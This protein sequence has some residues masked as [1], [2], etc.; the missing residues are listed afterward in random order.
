[1]L[2]LNKISAAKDALHYYTNQDNYYLSDRDSLN[3][4]SRWIGRGAQKLQLSGE[5]EPSQFLQLLDGQLPSGQL[6][7][8]IDKGVRQHRPG[9]D[10]T[11]S[12]PKS[13]SI[14]A[15][16][17]Q[18]ERLLQAHQE[19][20][21]ITF[22]R[23]EQL[24]A[25]ARITFN[26]ET[27]FEKTRNLVAA[28][29][30]HTTS[31]ELDPDL[32]THVPIL[33]MTERS[34]GLW[35]SLSSRAK[36]DKEHLDHGFRELI[37]SNQH[38]LGLVYMSSLAKK[39]KELGYDIRI[40]DR[41]GNF[42]IVGISDEAITA[43]SKRRVQILDDM[44]ERGTSS[45]K[46]AEKS[47]LSTRNPKT[48]IDS[49]ALHQQW[50][51]EIKDL[52][53]DLGTIIQDSKLNSGRG[54]VKSTHTTPL[55]TD[56]QKAVGDALAHLSE[57]STQIQHGALVRQAMI[58]SAGL[59]GHEDIEREIESLLAARALQ[60]K[61]LE[62]YTTAHL[63]AREKDFIA[64]TTNE[65]KVSF[66]IS[67]PNHGLTS[68]VFKNNERIQIIDIEGFRCEKELIQ[69]MV[70]LAEAH[71]LNSY[72]L[73]PGSL[74]TQQ[75]RA[76]IKHLDTGFI[77]RIKNLFKD[78][79]VHTVSGFQ[80]HYGKHIKSSPFLR[81]KQDLVIV[82]DAQ[83]LSFD[84]LSA[85]S[86]ITQ[87]HRSKLILLNNSAGTLGFSAGNPIKLLKEQGIH[88]YK[89][90]T[91]PIKGALKLSIGKQANE[92]MSS[93]WLQLTPEQQQKSA[94][95]ALNNKQKET[96][97]SQIREG[98]VQKG[99]LSRQMKK[100]AVL[101]TVSLT[102]TEKGYAH[103]YKVGDKITFYNEGRIPKH[104]KVCEVGVNGLHLEN[105][106]GKTSL[107]AYDAKEDFHVSREK[108]LEV[109]VGERLIN[110]QSLYHQRVKYAPKS[111]FVVSKIT[112][113]GIY[114]RHES[115][116]LFLTNK[117][118]SEYHFDY[119]YC[120][121]PHEIKPDTTQVFMAA[122]PYQLN[123]NLIGEIGENAQQVL[124]FTDD[125]QKAQR[126]LES[127]QLKWTAYDVQ[128]KKPDL[129]YRDMAYANKALEREI[130][131]LIH[132][133]SLKSEDK[134]GIAATALTYALAKCTER[135]AAFKHSDLMTHALMHALGEADFEDIAPLLKGRMADSLVYLDTYWTTK[136]ALHLE[137]AI[138]KVNY[139]EQNTVQPIEPSAQKL[140]SLPETLTQ[141]QKD[142]ITLVV[143][144]SDRFV[145]IQGLAGVGKTTMMR[146]VKDIAES[147][148]FQVLGL[149]PTHK[150]VEE[151]NANGI[152]AQT[153]DSFLRN[154]GGLGAN[155][156]VI[157]DESSMIDNEKYH[158][159]QQKCIDSQ[160]RMVFTG[161]IT[162]LQSLASGI[163]HELT[164]KSQ[165]QKTAFMTEIVRQN[166]NPE[167]KKAA[168][169]ASRREIGKAFELIKNINPEEYVQ[170][171]TPVQGLNHSSLIEINCTDEEG[172][173]DY[174]SIYRA[175]VDDFLSRTHECQKNTLIVAH[176][177]EDRTPIEVLIREG[178]HKQHQLHGQDILCKRL[179]PVSMDQ[180]DQVQAHSF[181]PGDVIRFG[182][183]YSV[184]K[185]DD[186]FTVKSIDREA[187][188]LFCVDES[189]VAFTISA[190]I[191][192][193]TMPS[194]YKLHE[195]PLASGDRIRLKRND[196]ARG[197]I[198]NEEYTV[199]QVFGETVGLSNSKNQVT[200]NLK[201]QLD[202]HW[203]YSYTNTA[204]SS[205]GATSK[206]MIALELED[207]LVVTTHRSHEIDATRASH[208]STF[209]TDNFEGLVKRL[210]DPLKQRDADKTSA[211][212]T[213]EDYRFKQQKQQ[214]IS[215]QLMN[216]AQEH[217]LEEPKEQVKDSPLIKKYESAQKPSI[218]AEELYNGLLNVSD[219][220]VKS[221]LGEPNYR[222]STQ[223][224][225]RY[226][227]KGSL[228]IDL[229]SGLWHHFET[230][231]SGNLFHLI[232][233]EKG[234]SGFKETL[235][236]AA[237]YIHYIPEYER[238][239]PQKLNE[240]KEREVKEGKRQLAQKLF[241]QSQPIQGTIAEKYLIIHRGLAHYDHADLRF[242]R[243]IYTKTQ[244]EQKHVPA[245][246][247]FSKD[248]QG[249]IH[250]VQITKLEPHSANKDKSCESVKQTFGSI[251]N[252]FVNLNHHGKGDIAYFTEGVETG[253]SILQANE[254]ARVYAVLGKANFSNIDPKDIPKQVVIC[255]DND[256]K[257]TYKY[258]K[259]EQ[260]NTIIK[261]AQR[262]HDSGI[263]VSIMIPK[264]ENTDLNDVLIKEGKDE[265]KKQLNRCM[266]LEEF[267]K[268][269]ALENKES[270]LKKINQDKQ[271]QSLIKQDRKFNAQSD[272]EFIRLNQGLINGNKERVYNKEFVENTR[273]FNKSRSN[274]E[275]EREL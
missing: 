237:Q 153:I 13:V 1:M 170:R 82:H 113:E 15:L 65:L 229:D 242:C 254:H 76:D 219:S 221:L 74:K 16:V 146:H 130:N 43:T 88:S 251:S 61:P 198:A 52:G 235:E 121:K 228:K 151:L 245:L 162:Q 203:D 169:F 20:V 22:G 85:L 23:I 199:T 264:K 50:V 95:V 90:L 210:E 100:V 24:A 21:N 190:S 19:A 258:A 267:K 135:N 25:E 89:S 77:S 215:T 256:G 148:Q 97:T 144:T 92:S 46:A 108:I 8:I 107:F 223:S 195:R 179:F 263:L 149:A 68:T 103:S 234:L 156:L 244:D 132:H 70:H 160:S 196:D 222:L 62:Y 246:L 129:V 35:R 178:L 54:A 192:P 137:E 171:K 98:L 36:N 265:L 212:F 271:I 33:N 102:Q 166:P 75:L 145:S 53:I 67:V 7:G 42:E 18:D 272:N 216:R 248:E 64:K 163:P 194:F 213:E 152:Q 174:T 150:A 84:D 243:S 206:F 110:E 114:V 227:A 106:Q 207:R 26:G 105:A 183:N 182:K 44:K 269:C 188:K 111:S 155:H 116:T 28:M 189:Q 201:K 217:I 225:Y 134:E 165:S 124:L 140:L 238:K 38:Y 253:L 31:R 214:R 176:A 159:L 2:T 147:N 6:L 247:A 220:L 186:Y 80:Y 126:F 37:Y 164:I 27:T 181:E 133:L 138:L 231:E 71:Q 128:Q 275:M 112:E 79:I 249:N 32:H 175:I 205:Q 200:L 81:K 86:D 41:Y 5:I 101:T 127:V 139:K 259:N 109:A 69:D 187:N 10:V 99:Q 120:K 125:E 255:L 167:L 11:L 72:V 123:R 93:A 60:G 141:G 66:S 240:K 274:R 73:H 173:K 55:S 122:R 197:I 94:L 91:A 40:K 261:V 209:Y 48:E 17:G 257:D 63:L 154:N 262:L 158:A 260:S 252:Y 211:V 51:D 191:L 30:V 45:A 224:E 202:L 9:T 14:L 4:L 273:T 119:D 96:L 204:Y 131:S 3:S 157:V 118:L 29:F 117:A 78:D 184:A 250:H 208:Q 226:G 12:A 172:K 270:E 168:E 161:D 136:E 230:G 56:A 104:Y 115:N 58:F 239:A 142:A 39:V 59:V 268:Q 180:A 233:R 87:A 236:H 83:K 57:Y 185:K 193:K 47:N 266:S 34:D 49:Q 241:Q 177:H 232:E 218:N 143:S